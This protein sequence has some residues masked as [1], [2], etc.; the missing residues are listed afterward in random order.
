MLFPLYASVFTRSWLRLLGVRVGKRA[1]VSVV[2][3]LN[4]LTSLGDMSFAADAAVFAS[5]RSR[6][7]WLYVGPVEVGD[8]SF[9]GKGAILRD[10]T[11]VGDGSLVGVMTLPH[12]RPAARTS[13]GSPALELPRV[14]DAADPSRTID[15]PRRL[16]L[17]RGVRIWSGSSRT[18]S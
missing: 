1:E 16:K 14:P 9:L 18:P 10:G 6:Q 4:R 8:R 7:G 3:G 17:A 11:R 5:T 15:P 13:F 12:A 2:S